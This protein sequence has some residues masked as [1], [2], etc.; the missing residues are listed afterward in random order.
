MDLKNN[1]L[2]SKIIIS[3][4]YIIIMPKKKNGNEN[5]TKKMTWFEAL[6]KWNTEKGGKWTIPKKGSKEYME[7]KAIYNK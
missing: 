1:L 6:K 7:I 4:I 3:N 2:L 5:G